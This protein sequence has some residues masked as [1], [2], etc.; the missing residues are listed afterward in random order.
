MVTRARLVGIGKPSKYLDLPLASFG[1]W[2]TVALKRARRAMPQ[3]MKPVKM[4]VSA[5]V[6]IPIT[7]A[8][9][10]GATPKEICSAVGHEAEFSGK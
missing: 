1:T 6:R 10:A 7:H 4:S 5:F 3:Q 9:N 2:A 8:Q